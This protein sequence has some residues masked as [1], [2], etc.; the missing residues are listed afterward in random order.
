M[1]LRL[2]VQCGLRAGTHTTAAQPPCIPAHPSLAALD[3]RLAEYFRERLRAEVDG[4]QYTPPAPNA[5][6]KM[7]PRNKSFATGPQHSEWDD[8]GG[9][10]GSKGGGGLAGTSGG[11][12]GGGGG[13][14]GSEYTMSQ[15]QASANQK[16]SFFNRKIAENA[17][18]P[19]GLPPSQ[20][21]KYVG[22]GSQPAARPPGN[23]PPNAINVDEVSQVRLWQKMCTAVW[24]V[25]LSESWGSEPGCLA[26]GA[27]SSCVASGCLPVSLLPLLLRGPPHCA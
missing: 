24:C 26:A 25:S 3:L 12:G 17:T 23:C 10:G 9:D 15:L 16:D 22:F 18:R 21:G 6:N 5:E 7:M 4:R 19:E 1:T 14:S 2:D 11:G 20:G 8:W 13:R 27:T